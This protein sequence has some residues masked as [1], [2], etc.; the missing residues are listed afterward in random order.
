APAIVLINRALARQYFPNQDPIGQRIKLGDSLWAPIVGIAGD[1]RE[2][3]LEAPSAPTLYLSY[4]QF[5][6]N[7]I[8]L[9][10]STTVPPTNVT[11]AIRAAIRS[12]D[13]G[14][15]VY[16]VETME[17]VVAESVSSSRFDFWLLGTFAAIA[18]ALAA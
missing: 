9:V 4:L 5:P 6:Q 3:Q 15:P 10:V 11:P 2:S 7:E 12:V 17:H 8:T 14:Q 18:L 1:V 13:P 16:D